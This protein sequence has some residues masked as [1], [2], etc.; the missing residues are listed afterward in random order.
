MGALG[1][2][3]TLREAKRAVEWEHLAALKQRELA[4]QIGVHISDEDFNREY[5]TVLHDAVHRAVTGK[6]SDPQHEGFRPHAHRV[7]LDVAMRMLDEAAKDM[8]LRDEHDLLRKAD[9]PA[10]LDDLRRG[11]AKAIRD[12]VAM[13]RKR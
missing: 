2:H 3:R 1:K 10:T 6:F 8:G 11:V 7:P 4:S 13:A 5:N 9:E 12:A